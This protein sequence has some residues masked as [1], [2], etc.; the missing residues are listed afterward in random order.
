MNFLDVI[1]QTSHPITAEEIAVLNGMGLQLVAAVDELSYRFRGESA[2]GLDDI[3]ALPFVVDAQFCTVTDKLDRQLTA[4][5]RIAGAAEIMA[6]DSGLVVP[7]VPVHVL[8]SLDQQ[9]NVQNTLAE[10][11][12]IG[13]VLDSSARRALVEVDRARVAELAALPGVLAAEVEPDPRIQNNVAR[14]LIGVAPAAVNLGLDGSGEIVGV[15]DS[16]LD[17]GVNDATMLADF[18]GRIVNIRA[19]VNKAAFGVA[20]G[21][22]L[23]NHGTH[24]SGSILGDGSN[25]NGNIAGMAPAAQVT[26]LSMGPNNGS[27]LSVPLDLYTGIF[28]D[29]YTDGARLHNNSWGSTGSFGAYTA[30][31]RDVDEFMRDNRDMLILIAAG[32]EGS[33]GAG[34]VSAP[35]TAK[36]CLTVGASESVRPLPATISINP[37]LQDAD[38]NPATP[39]TN[40]PLSISNFDLQADDFED[41]AAFSGLGPTDDG[42]IAPD[43]VAPGTFILSARSSVSTADLG[44]DG[45]PHVPPLNGFYA[46]DADGIATHA[47]AVGRGLP[48][49]PFFGTWNQNTPTA[50]AGSGAL[51]QD[52]YFFN[53]GTSMATPITSGATALLRQYLRQQRGIANPSG[54]LIKAMLINGATVPVGESNAPNNSRG[55]GWLNMANTL[56][57]NPTGQQGY[58]DDLDLAVATG[59]VRSFS[60]QIADTTQPFR[61]TLA[62]TDAPGSGLQNRLYLRV[63]A[64][65]GT[66]T[67]GDVSAFPTASNNVQ[68]VHIASPLAGA[69][70]IEVHGLSV[71][72]GIAAFLPALRQDFALAII[73]GIG[74]SPEPVDVVQVIDRSGSMDFYGFMEPAKARARQLVSM[75]RVSDRTGVVSFNGTAATNNPVIP[76]VGFADQT[77]INANVTAIVAG[78]VTSIGAGLQ[79]AITDLA[80]GGDP[81]HPQAFV[82]LSDGYENTP[83]WVGGAVMDSPPAWYGGPDF[84]EVLPTLP[85]GVRVYTVSLGVQSDQVLLQELATATGGIFHAVH[86]AADIAKI[87]EIY[88]HLQA[89]AGG[90]EVIAS[91]DSSVDGMTIGVAGAVAPVVLNGFEDGVLMSEWSGLANLNE[92][93]PDPSFLQGFISTRIHRVPVDESMRTLTMMVSW[94]D[95]DRPVSLSLITPSQK[96]IKAG[97][98]V[99]FNQRGDSFQFF[100][101][102]EPEPGEWQM[103]VRS[104]RRDGDSR[105]ATHRYTFGAYGKSPLGIEVELPRELAGSP[106]LKLTAKLAGADVARTVRFSATVNTPRISVDNLLELNKD[107]LA[108]IDLG[109][110]PDS[111]RVDANLFKLAALDGARAAKGEASLFSLRHRRLSLTRTNG[112]SNS[113]ATPVAGLHTVNL[114]VVGRSNAGHQYR[115]QLNFSVRI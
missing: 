60:V 18:A 76:I 36:N 84:T 35:G 50:P 2:A 72:F 71:T 5:V 43:L 112:Y 31:S 11:D 92:V 37:N 107:A 30:F 64:P 6:A 111:P 100:R 23:N 14:T 42:R 21:A 95:P 44:P 74:I 39:A 65:D 12:S 113:L 8:V 109:F 87:H 101:L 98:A 45:Q 29:A 104:D 28:Q 86:S 32:N 25:S 41:I 85:A 34:S 47:E 3:R 9:I 26:M 69:Y 80:A 24:V 59:D 40:V 16:G 96:V 54:A 114:A 89:L 57:P 33:G 97:S 58:S 115:R 88:V 75:L 4:Q 1:V 22:D 49:A 15:A 83:P 70:T 13:I 52:N 19:T 10:L 90:E 93:F 48:G 55:F 94:H 102:D 61:V 67:D 106:E 20:N 53:S 79:R 66:V 62:W 82:L 68:R 91:G 78:G 46:N 103:L 105:W 110:E 81:T 63:I 73:N 56:T 77:A 99:V 7:P 17:N 108:Q 38:F 27:G 51:A